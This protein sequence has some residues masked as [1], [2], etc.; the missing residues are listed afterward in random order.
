MSERKESELRRLAR[1]EAKLETCWWRNHHEKNWGET[2]KCMAELYVKLYNIS[3]EI[4]E[5][6]V[7]L[8]IKAA[9]EHDLAEKSGI[10]KK[11]YDKH[12]KKVE[13]I[14]EKHFFMLEK[15]RKR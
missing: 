1:A 7:I 11:E 13:E 12:W 4:A 8:R 2:I 10:S 15:N 9:K 6:M 14:N 3:F 5:K